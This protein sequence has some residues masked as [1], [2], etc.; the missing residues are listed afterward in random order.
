MV[1]HDRFFDRYAA[2]CKNLGI[3]PS[4]QSTA[5][6]LETTRATITKWNTLNI[7][8]KGEMVRRIADAFGVST[9]YLLGRTDDPTDYV[10]MGGQAYTAL[11]QSNTVPFPKIKT[12][13]KTQQSKIQVL[14]DQLDD[15]DKIKAEGVIQGMLMQDKYINCSEPDMGY[16]N[17][18]HIR[19]DIE[20]TPEMLKHD[21][22]I[23]NDDD[24]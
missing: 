3:S 11:K 8:P 24:F 20:I 22:D 9:D 2:I 1:T 10:R 15:S 12:D 16:V 4:S 17:A 18:A 21:D 13:E 19:T 5:E 6:R 23:M 7:T 14:Y